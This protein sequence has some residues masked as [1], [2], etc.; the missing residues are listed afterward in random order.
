[1]ACALVA[2][3]ALGVSLSAQRPAAR[4]ERPIV[5]SGRGPRRLAIDVPLLVG[6]APFRDVSR[7][8]N[9]D[10]G[11]VRTVARAGLSDLRFAD[12]AGTE[13]GYVLVGPSGT[14][15][16]WRAGAILP[17]APVETEKEKTSGFELDLS[18]RDLVDRFRIDG[19]PP[20]FLKRARLE[21]SGDRSHWT[22]LVDEGT[23]FDLPDQ[24]LRQIEL[25]F[26]PGSFRYFR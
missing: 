16:E 23:L 18:G 2:V 24:R 22:L 19:L 9:P 13:V 11:E 6:A 7:I 12:Q 17:V 1:T 25:A 3:S 10:T 26:E 5:T 8:A 15:P 4:Y 14:Q 20:P 21:A